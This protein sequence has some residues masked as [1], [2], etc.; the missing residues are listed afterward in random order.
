MTR[1]RGPLARLFFTSQGKTAVINADGSGLKW[2]EFDV[3]NQVTWQPGS[4]FSDGRSTVL[5]SMEPRRDGPGKPFDEYYTQTPTHIWKYNLDT[6]AL[7][8][9][10]NQDRLAPFETPALLVSDD[11]ILVQVVKNRVGQI[12]SMKL[13]GTD[14]R[15]FTHGGEGLPYG[16]SLGPTRAASRFIWPAPKVIKSGPATSTARTASRSRRIRITCT[17]APVGR[18]TA[19]GSCTLTAITRTSRGMIGRTSASAGPTAASIAC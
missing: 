14:A 19:S 8:E 17:S 11:R 16:L 18:P 1:T 15:D 7:D 5:L 12:V 2:L 6:G 13:D 3:P 4:T 10:C 9:I